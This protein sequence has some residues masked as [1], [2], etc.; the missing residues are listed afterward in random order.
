MLSV[1]L[2]AMIIPFFKNIATITSR[3]WAQAAATL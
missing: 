2:P 1:N 3:L